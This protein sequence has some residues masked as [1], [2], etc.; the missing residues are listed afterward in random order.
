MLGAPLPI[1]GRGSSGLAWDAF[2][3]DRGWPG[4]WRR[5]HPAPEASVPY[6]EQGYLFLIWPRPPVSPAADHGS[7]PRGKRTTTPCRSRFQIKRKAQESKLALTS[8]GTAT[9]SLLILQ[10]S[11]TSPSAIFL[12][13][14]FVKARPFRHLTRASSQ[15]HPRNW[16]LSACS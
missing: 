2:G 10:P 14:S 3:F 7:S 13:R 15:G 11:N 16:T 9:G 5:H 6:P 4:S 8:A 1:H 12:I